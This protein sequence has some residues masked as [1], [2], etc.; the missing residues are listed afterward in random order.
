MEGAFLRS[1]RELANR[2]HLAVFPTLR[3]RSPMKEKL[4]LCQPDV[5]LQPCWNLLVTFA[6]KPI[7]FAT[8]DTRNSIL[9]CHVK[10]DLSSL[11]LLPCYVARVSGAGGEGARPAI[12]SLY[13]PDSA[14]PCSWSWNSPSFVCH[15]C[16]KHH[17]VNTF[18]CSSCPHAAESTLVCIHI[19][20]W[21][22]LSRDE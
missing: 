9:R 15:L 10:G 16:R 7:P 21:T 19:P 17:R 18:C 8:D 11:P 2:V 22:L 4:R 3:I 5:K 13:P 1:C 14:I 6:V 20:P 12:G